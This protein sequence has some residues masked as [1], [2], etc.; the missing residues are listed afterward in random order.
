VIDRMRISVI[1]VNT[2]HILT[3]DLVVVEPMLVRTL[4]A[5][6]HIE[7]KIPA[8]EEF[9]SSS[10]INWKNWGQW[11]VAEIEVN[12]VRKIYG[13][14]IVSDNKV[15]PESG[16]MQIQATGFLGY[17]KGIQWLENYNPIAV[18]PAEVIERIWLHL[19]SYSNAYMEIGVTPTSTGTQMLPGYGFDGSILS[20]DFFAMFIRA[21]DFTDCGDVITGLA[22]DLPLDLF[23]QVAWN[24][25]QTALVKN[26]F[27]AYPNGGFQQNNLSFRLGENIIMAEP[28]DELDIEP[29]SD[30]IIRGW[31]PGKTYSSI[32][33][34][35]DA[36]RLRR[37]M[38][39]EDSHIDSTERAQ[40]LA[41]RKLTRRNIP[42]SLSKI[43]V[44]HSHPNAPFGSFDIGDSIYIQAP[45]FPWIGDVIGWH[46]VTS[47]AYK[48]GEPTLEVGVKVDGAWNY[49]PITYDPDYDS[50]PTE[51]NN[52]LSNGYFQQSLGG[53]SS[54]K[55]QWFRVTGFGYDTGNIG[56]SNIGSV[57]VDTDDH[58]E[59]FLSNRF[60]V[61]PGEHLKIQAGVRWDNVVAGPTDFFSIVGRFYLDG[62]LIS[63]SDLDIHYNPSGNH[64]W[65]RLENASYAV[66]A[67]VNEMAIQLTVSNGVSNGTS[68]W[69]GIRVIDA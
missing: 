30:I 3:R 69:S 15:D 33:S 25:D 49:D 24:I 36:T 23:E 4:S 32:L 14:G 13:C 50:E 65:L 22:R 21:V 34:N 57:R 18:D 46:R 56:V 55:G 44:D 11:V 62:A 51:D 20:F 66:P 52:R 64:A 27:I 29:V 39:E 12:G 48:D 6:C 45:N 60:T 10:G 9:R 1:E 38:M 40:A 26:V 28:A 2:N 37:T 59:A 67:G 5:P 8:S 35:A 16:A 41:K 53:W 47:I 63:S 61:V 43:V 42:K 7:F 54:I 19:Q 31:L 58:G 17:P 68:W